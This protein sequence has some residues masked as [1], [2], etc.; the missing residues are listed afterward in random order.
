MNLWRRLLLRTFG[1]EQF[2]PFT[3]KGYPD[4]PVF[5]HQCGTIQDLSPLSKDAL[6]DIVAGLCDCEN[7][8][9]WMKVYIKKEEA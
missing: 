2:V 4:H 3:F 8:S 9:P 5:I 7:T 1:A 6:A